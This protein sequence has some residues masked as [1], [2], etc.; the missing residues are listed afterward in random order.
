VP[1]VGDHLL[2]FGSPYGLDGTVTNGIVGRVRRDGI[3]T[4]A[5]A[6]PGNSGGPAVDG[7]GR[8]V[9]V[10]RAGIGDD[11]SFLVPVARACVRIRRCR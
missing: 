8:V 1:A 9:G 3:V 6:N 11:L 10:L 2:L 4:D 5:A 7:E